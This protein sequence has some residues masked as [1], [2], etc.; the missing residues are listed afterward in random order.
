M[1]GIQTG[2]V[3]VASLAQAL[4]PLLPP[5]VTADQLVAAF[6]AHLSTPTTGH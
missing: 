2:Q 1:K 4:V 6:A 3:D 5:N